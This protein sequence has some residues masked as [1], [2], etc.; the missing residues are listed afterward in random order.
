MTWH[1]WIW[2]TIYFLMHKDSRR[3]ITF[4][5]QP[6]WFLPIMVL[7]RAYLCSFLMYWGIQVRTSYIVADMYDRPYMNLV[8]MCTLSSISNIRILKYH[9]LHSSAEMGRYLLGQ[10]CLPIMVLIRAHLCSFPVHSQCL[11]DISSL[12]T[13]CS[14]P[15]LPTSCGAVIS[16]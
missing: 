12:V 15:A 6:I 1:T 3:I 9:L 13:Y 14:D 7:P 4:L 8:A 5:Q 16:R 2:C 11:M 10:K